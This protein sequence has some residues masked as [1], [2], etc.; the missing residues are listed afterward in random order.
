MGKIDVSIDDKLEQE[1][2]EEIFK[3]KGMKKGNIK[4]AVEE[5]LRIWIDTRK[6]NRS[7][8]AKKAVATME[9]N[10]RNELPL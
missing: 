3:S 8:A 2:K 7:N 6:K 10:K 4:I 5:A 9:K 1:F